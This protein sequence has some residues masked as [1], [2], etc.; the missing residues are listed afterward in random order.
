LLAI[1]GGP[2]QSAAAQKAVAADG[3]PIN[4]PWTPELWAEVAKLPD[5]S[6]TWTP[7]ITDQVA[8]ERGNPPPWNEKAAK[9]I[10]AQ[11]ADFK[12][13]RPHLV[14][15]NCVP[16]SMPSWML[17]SHNSL[18]FLFTPGRVTMLGESDSNRLRRVYTDGRPH[19]EDPDLTFHGHS[20]GHWEGDVLVIDTVGVRP[21]AT[22]AISEAHGVPN[23]GDMHIKERIYLK[24]P[25]TMHVEM[26]ITAPHVLTKPW[27]ST[28]IYYRQRKQKFDIVE[29]ICIEAN[30]NETLDKD[31]NHIFEWIDSRKDGSVNPESN[32]DLAPPTGK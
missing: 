3:D 1:A 2:V 8:Q 17:I 16:E 27:K 4:P 11:D 29:G 14:F 15:S 23:N 31:G 26:E 12:A 20:I 5:W 19:P 21:Q 9:M 18:E 24:N 22:I 30:L 25:V 13:G 6:G 7:D 28:R 32:P 10:V